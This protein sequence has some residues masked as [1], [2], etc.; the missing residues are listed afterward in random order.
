MTRIQLYHDGNKIRT[1]FHQERNSNILIVITSI[2]MILGF[3]SVLV[4]FTFSS[5]H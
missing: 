4:H 2:D 3:Q 5:L 1:Q